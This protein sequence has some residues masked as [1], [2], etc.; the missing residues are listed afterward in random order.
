[1]KNIDLLVV[2]FEKALLE[3]DRVKADE[4]FASCFKESADSDMLELLA[5]KTLERI[6]EGW[7]DGSI[8]L[9]QVY[10]GG[11]ICE[12]LI[13]KY[14]PGCEVKR[15]DAPVMAIAVLQDHHALGKRLVYSVLRTAGFDVLDLGQGL[16]VDDLVEKAIEN[17]VKILLISALMLP[18]A[19][20]VKAVKEKF[21]ENGADIKIIV[22]G[23]PFRLD[24][25][26]WRE[27]G[28]DR[29]ASTA[30][31]ILK[32]IEQIIREVA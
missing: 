5:T 3:V 16:S 25:D 4:I 2:E 32:V 29:E 17:K 8:S 18:S 27:V 22:G 6:G 11:V 9:A 14:L 10:M 31:D 21:I 19:L 28:A 23:A 30:S 26:L 24:K 13:A 20:K 12:E 15:T 7:D 1:M